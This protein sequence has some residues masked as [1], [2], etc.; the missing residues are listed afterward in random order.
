[1][2]K[3]EKINFPHLQVRLIG[4]THLR[5]TAYHP[6][7]NGMV[8][9][10]HRQMKAAL[11]CHKTKAWAEILSIILL[12]IRATIKEDLKASSYELFYGTTIRLPGKFFLI[13]K[14]MNT[15]DFV[16]NLRKKMRALKPV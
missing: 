5:T 2:L 10:L 12:G 15:S 13:S 4:A 6:A 14:S 11:K 9:R 16:E 1:M 3:L 8:E 7:A